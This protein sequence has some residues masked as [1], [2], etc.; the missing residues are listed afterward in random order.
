MAYH[1]ERQS[2]TFRFAGLRVTRLVH[3]SQLL[4]LLV[5]QRQ[6]AN[7]RGPERVLLHGHWWLLLVGHTVDSR[8]LGGE[9]VGVVEERLVLDAEP[10]QEA[11]VGR[12]QQVV[13]LTKVVIFDG[14]PFLSYPNEQKVSN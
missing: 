11:T 14:H 9:P 13:Q 12:Q 1:S 2:S 4:V 10:E 5:C 7:E 8:S 3:R 6:I